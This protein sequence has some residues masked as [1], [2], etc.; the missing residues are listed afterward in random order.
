MILINGMSLI[1]VLINFIRSF[2]FLFR[3]GFKS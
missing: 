1:N 3:A 2:Y